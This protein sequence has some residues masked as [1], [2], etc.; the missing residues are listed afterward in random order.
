MPL[1]L[2][3]VS[4]SIEVSI[5]QCPGRTVMP[6]I[7]LY[8]ETSSAANVVTM[9]I[10]RSSEFRHFKRS[11]KTKLLSRFSSTSC[12]SPLA[13]VYIPYL[14]CGRSFQRKAKSTTNFVRIDLYN[15]GFVLAKL[16]HFHRIAATI[17]LQEPKHPT[18]PPVANND[19]NTMTTH[20]TSRF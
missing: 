17:W 6:P 9:L 7:E 10:F 13:V 4:A 1:F 16:D 11:A 20:P 2:C 5:G 18:K 3:Y 15:F 19:S 14:L 12:R 8:F